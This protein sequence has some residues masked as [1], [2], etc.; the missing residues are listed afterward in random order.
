MTMRSSGGTKSLT[1]RKVVWNLWTEKASHFYATKTSD[2]RSVPFAHR[3]NGEAEPSEVGGFHWGW[4][5]L[6]R[7]SRRCPLPSCNS[8][9]QIDQGARGYQRPPQVSSIGSDMTARIR[10]NDD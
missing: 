3:G 7:R 9:E 4:N 2:L 5:E 10:D 8:D 6:H 1:H